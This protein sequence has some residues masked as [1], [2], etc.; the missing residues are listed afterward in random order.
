MRSNLPFNDF[1]SEEVCLPKVDPV[2]DIDLSPSEETLKTV[3]LG[4]DACKR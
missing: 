3:P 4:T 2:T 1:P